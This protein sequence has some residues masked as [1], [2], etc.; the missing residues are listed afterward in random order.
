MA[1]YPQRVT[2]N[3]LG[4]LTFG[5]VGWDGDY[6]LSGYGLDTFGFIWGIADIWHPAEECQAVVWTDCPCSPDCD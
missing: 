5:F 6:A 2:I 3:P 1:I 4:Q